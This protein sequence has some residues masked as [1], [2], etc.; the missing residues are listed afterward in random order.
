MIWVTL[1]LQCT[2]D[3]E[4]SRQRYATFMEF[5]DVSEANLLTIKLTE[6]KLR[7]DQ[8]QLPDTWNPYRGALIRD[9]AYV[10]QT[11]DELVA[12][13]MIR[14]RTRQSVATAVADLEILV[15]TIERLATPPNAAGSNTPVDYNAS[16]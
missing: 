3:V 16:E 1:A 2:R 13:P 12:H 10:S 8:I 15:R 11:V 14:S 6:L 4:L 5:V 9:C 7:L